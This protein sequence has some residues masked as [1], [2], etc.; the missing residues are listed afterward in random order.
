MPALLTRRKLWL[1]AGVSLLAGVAAVWHFGV[2]SRSTGPLDG[3]V[4]DCDGDRVVV[5]TWRESRVGDPI[6]IYARVSDTDEMDSVASGTVVA[7][8]G[9]EV[10]AVIEQRRGELDEGQIAKIGNIAL[11]REPPP[12][13]PA[14]DR[15]APP[16][17]E[18]TA[19]PPTP[20][21]GTETTE[22]TPPPSGGIPPPR[23]MTPEEYVQSIRPKA[24][25]GDANAQSELG[26]AL[27]SGIG[28][29]QNPTEAV[30]WL[31]LAADQGSQNARVE[32]ARLH[33]F[34]PEMRI[35]LPEA[36]QWLR[37]AA[38]LR[39]LHAQHHLASLLLQGRIGGAP[40][41]TQALFWF[42]HAAEAGF[43]ESMTG[44]GYMHVN[45]LGTPKDVEK[46][47]EWYKKAVALGSQAAQ[48]NLQQLGR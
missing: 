21:T 3:V 38:A 5:D 40:D 32:L 1:V 48:A 2:G 43:A 8:A 31:S 13:A 37:D 22:V 17:T 41:Y 9:N 27:L 26:L 7:V 19:P 34:A 18:T 16:F 15:P 11:E 12:T 20:V 46:G 44:L 24:E 29:T 10:T 39:H 47:V 28:A 14:V 23:P 42:Q 36:E 25:N 45:G 35:N 4:A 6:T 30:R 33:Y